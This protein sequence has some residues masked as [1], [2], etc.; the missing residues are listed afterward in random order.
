MCLNFGN[1][2][3][4]PRKHPYKSTSFYEFALSKKAMK[5]SDVI[6]W[7]IL[8]ILWS[9][10]ILWQLEIEK[11]S[12][13]LQKDLDRYDLYMLPIFVLVSIYVVRHLVQKKN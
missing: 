8:L 10:F 9:L 2:D 7:V 6:L 11:L 3:V 1:G 12:P 5:F 13:A 4:S